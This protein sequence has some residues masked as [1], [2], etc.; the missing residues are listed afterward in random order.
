[1]LRLITGPRIVV[2]AGDMAQ[3]GGG[4]TLPEPPGPGVPVQ[5]RVEVSGSVRGGSIAA[6]PPAAPRPPRRTFW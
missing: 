4:V 1:V 5:L 2:D 3:H 6:G